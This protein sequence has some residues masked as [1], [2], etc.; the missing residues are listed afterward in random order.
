MISRLSSYA[1][2]FPHQQGTLAEVSLLQLRGYCSSARL[3][4]ETTIYTLPL[5]R[6]NWAN[7]TVNGDDTVLTSLTSPFQ[8]KGQWS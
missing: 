4:E 2:L 1:L 8:P 3:S 6:P 5:Y 7:V